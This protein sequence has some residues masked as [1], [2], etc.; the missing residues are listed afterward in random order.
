MKLKEDKAD[1]QKCHVVNG[2]KKRNILS[3]E[4]QQ[5]GEGEREAAN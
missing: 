4:E 3:K 1:E 2:W 5:G